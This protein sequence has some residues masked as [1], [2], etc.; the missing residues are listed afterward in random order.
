[1]G[2]EYYIYAYVRKD[3]SP[4][5]IGKGKG[6]RAYAKGSH[7]VKLPDMSRILILEKGLTN[8]GA[9]ALER[10]YIRWYGKKIDKT[11]ILRNITDGGEGNTGP[12]SE[13]WKENHRRMMTGRKD[14]EA[15]KIK[16]KNINRDYMK[17]EEYKQKARTSALRRGSRKSH[18]S[19]LIGRRVRTP[20]GEFQS[21]REAAKA[22]KITVYYIYKFMK[23]SSS[24]F[25]YAD[26]KT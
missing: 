19:D 13:T 6:M 24:G 7:S 8:I 4:Y 15:T 17:T 26:L 9:C 16:K 11:G 1:M 20:L 21:V 18:P 10:F 25:V 22:H 2:C 5:Y 3:G 12:R 23:D 14:S